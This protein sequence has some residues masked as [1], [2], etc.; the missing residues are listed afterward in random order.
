M[1][2][3]DEREEDGDDDARSGFHKAIALDG[4][5][6]RGARLEEGPKV[7]LV[8]VVTH[9]EAVTIAQANVDTKTNEIVRPERRVVTV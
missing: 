2:E 5:T 6:L 9:E 8:S 3:D 1:V 7:H 4:K